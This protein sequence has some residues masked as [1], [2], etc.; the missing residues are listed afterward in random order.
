MLLGL[1][2]GGT[3]RFP[4][5]ALPLADLLLT[6]HVGRFSGRVV[7]GMPGDEDGAP[8]ASRPL[9]GGAGGRRRYG[10]GADLAFFRE[11]GMV[12][13]ERVGLPGVVGLAD[14]LVEQGK[15]DASEAEAFL[16]VADDGFDLARRLEARGLVARADLDVAVAEHA[17][18]RL[19]AR[20]SGEGTPVRVRAGLNALARFHAVAIDARPAIAFGYVVHGRISEKRAIMERAASR[21]VRLVARYDAARNAYGLPPPVIAAVRELEG[22]GLVLS[23]KPVLRT[24]SWSDTAGLFLLMDRIG[25]LV[26]EDS[27][28]ATPGLPD[29]GRNLHKARDEVSLPGSPTRAESGSRLS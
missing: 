21:R 10:V 5:A 24:L 26:I 16:G 14:V 8:R 17:R 18:R 25:L 9:E 12:G 19:F 20:A 4:L 6:L 1:E 7:L 11:G 23:R 27:G 15:L 3:M 29:P 28:G 13:L 22:P 2:P